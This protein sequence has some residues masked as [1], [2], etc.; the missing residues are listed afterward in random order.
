MASGSNAHHHAA[1]PQ[2]IPAFLTLGGSRVAVAFRADGAFAKPEIYA[3]LE[4][5]GMKYAIRFPTKANRLKE[6]WNGEVY[7]KSLEKV[8]PYP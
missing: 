4:E 3:S 1:S 8:F 5:R 6:G 7:E 2:R